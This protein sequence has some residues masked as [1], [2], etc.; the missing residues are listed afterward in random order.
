M[1]TLYRLVPKFE[2]HKTFMIIALNFFYSIQIFYDLVRQINKK[3]PGPGR[4]KKKKSGCAL[5]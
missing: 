2:M 4:E 5:L 3:N 1:C